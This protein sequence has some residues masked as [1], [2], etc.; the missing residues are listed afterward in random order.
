MNTRYI[1]VEG[2]ED[3]KRDNKTGAIL[4]CDRAKLLEA[5]KKK[6]EAERYINLEQRIK[7]LEQQVQMLLKGNNQ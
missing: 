3:I 6:Q 1:K 5:K 7:K 2:R 4:A